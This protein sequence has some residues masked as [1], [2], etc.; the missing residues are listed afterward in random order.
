M[1]RHGDYGAARDQFLVTVPPGWWFSCDGYLM[2]WTLEASR[3]AITADTDLLLALL[4]DPVPEIRVSA[5]DALGAALGN[6]D[7]IG[8]A[9]RD[10]LAVEQ[11]P[12]V[13]AGLVLACAELARGH[14]DPDTAGWLGTLW[15][16]PVQ[17]AGIRVAAALA[18]L[19][20][21]DCA[22]PDDLRDMVDAFVAADVHGV[23]NGVP[24]I[25]RTGGL[26]ATVGQMLH[27]TPVGDPIPLG[28]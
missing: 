10:R 19:C 7:R 3:L 28:C 5:G 12:A 18:W 6:V 21:T 24:W 1:A 15:P 25:A 4:H 14:S 8:E 20:L 27:G 9:L 16:D 2:T 13:R 17:P 26:A 11:V 22:V 23:L